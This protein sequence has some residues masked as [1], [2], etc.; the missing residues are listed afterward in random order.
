LYEFV[1]PL[2]SPDGAIRGAVAAVVDVTGRKQTEESLRQ[3]ARQQAAGARLG[4]LALTETGLDHLLGQAVTTVAETLEV[5]LCKALELLP[6]GKEV[7][8]RAGVGWKPGLV[9]RGRVSA[10]M[11]SQAGYT[12]ASEQPVIGED[13]RTE[14]RFSG[15]PLLH[16][17]GVI[18]GISCIIHTG[19]E[20]GGAPDAGAAERGHSLHWGVLGAHSRSPRKFT[21]D[22]V[23]FLQAVA[24]VLGSAIRQRRAEQALRESQ[25]HLSLAMIAGRMGAWEYDIPSGSVR[26]SSTLEQIHG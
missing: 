13:M 9:R 12:L 26:W 14:T 11:E 7:C 21:A 3:R 18:S 23:N 22:D 8:L 20:S 24:N 2:R 25:G 16:D 5:E 17:H 15:P 4:Q 19:E 6:D 1:A 10:G